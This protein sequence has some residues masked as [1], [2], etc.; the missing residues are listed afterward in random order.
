MNL[1]FQHGYFGQMVDI[2]QKLNGSRPEGLK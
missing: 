1:F 2:E